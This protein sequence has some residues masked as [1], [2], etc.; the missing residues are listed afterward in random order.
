MCVC[1]C[2][3]A[4]CRFCRVRFSGAD[5][6]RR[7]ASDDTAVRTSSPRLAEPPA[8]HSTALALTR[9]PVRLHVRFSVGTSPE[10]FL[11]KFPQNC[12]LFSYRRRR[13]YDV[14]ADVNSNKTK[15]KTLFLEPQRARSVFI[16]FYYFISYYIIQKY[17]GGSVAEW[18]AC[19]T[20]EQKGPVSNH[21]RE[22]CRVAVLGKLFTPIVPLFTK[23]Q[24][25]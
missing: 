20:H 5:V 8:T 10:I 1:V 19:W 14:N 18:L 12:P 7:S 6:S 17:K 25:W 23:Q 22:S 21:S 4:L 13:P 2:V 16:Y 24:N 15:Q 11:G 3:Y 9:L